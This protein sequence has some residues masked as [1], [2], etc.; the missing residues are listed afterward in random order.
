MSQYIHLQ[1]YK[2]I[3]LGKKTVRIKK[4]TIGQTIAASVNIRAWQ[5][6]KNTKRPD[7][8][9]LNEL[10]TDCIIPEKVLWFDKRPKI[11]PEHRDKLLEEIRD[12]NGWK[13]PEKQEENKDPIDPLWVTHIIAEMGFK[14]GYSKEEVLGLYIEEVNELLRACAEIERREFNKR[15]D[16]NFISAMYAYNNPKEYEKYATE[17]D[18]KSSIKTVDKKELQKMLDIE[19]EFLARSGVK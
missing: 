14:L 13:K 11:K 6:T 5:L 17:R 19:A 16:A 9:A 3:T 10:F 4:L 18:R 7:H 15:S 12:L 8:D 1:V 2:K